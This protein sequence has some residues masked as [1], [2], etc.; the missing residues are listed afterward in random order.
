[1]SRLHLQTVGLAVGIP[2]CSADQGHCW[3][4]TVCAVYMR[5]GAGGQG[6]NAGLG[7]GVGPG[8]KAIRRDHTGEHATMIQGPR[9]HRC[10]M[11]KNCKLQN[12]MGSHGG[13][14]PGQ[15]VEL[16]ENVFIEPDAVHE[17]PEDDQGGER[18]VPLVLPAFALYDAGAVWTDHIAHIL[19]CCKHD[20]IDQPV[21]TPYGTKCKFALNLSNHWAVLNCILQKCSASCWFCKLALSL[22]PSPPLPPLPLRLLS[23]QASAKHMVQS[24]QP[25]VKARQH[26]PI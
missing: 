7:P 19:S 8:L 25:D 5:S 23:S 18:N 14:T 17:D 22:T 21:C 20:S 24:S 9:S 16:L 4:G 1:M 15:P 3:G 10:H 12:C 13:S 26:R 2:C 11:L 6:V